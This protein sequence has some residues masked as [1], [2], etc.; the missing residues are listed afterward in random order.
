MDEADIANELAQLRLEQGVSH[1]R[2]AA[3]VTEAGDGI[4][5]DCDEDIPPARMK[6]KPGALRCISCQVDYEYRM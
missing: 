4:C 1:I 3:A 5:I 6:A 2:A